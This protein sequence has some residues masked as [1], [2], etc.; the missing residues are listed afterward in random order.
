MQYVC[1]F[2]DNN[3]TNSILNLIANHVQCTVYNVQSST[4]VST[5]KLMKSVVFNGI[6]IKRV[7]DKLKIIKIA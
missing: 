3:G 1:I 7:D 5:A 6:V 2:D 4:V